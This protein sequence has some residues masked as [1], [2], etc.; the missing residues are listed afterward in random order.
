MLRLL[1]VRISTLKFIDKNNIYDK[2]SIIYGVFLAPKAPKTILDPLSTRYF[3]NLAK[4]AQ[5]DQF[6]SLKIQKDQTPGH[7]PAIATLKS[8]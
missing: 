6:W 2:N 5:K 7:P 3:G 1:K 8:I 4:I